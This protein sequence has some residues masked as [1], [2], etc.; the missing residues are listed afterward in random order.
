MFFSI[1]FLLALHYGCFLDNCFLDGYFLDGCF[2]NGC[3]LD[4]YFLNEWLL[5]WW[6]LFRSLLLGRLLLT[7]NLNKTPFGN[8]WRL[9]NPYFILNGC[10][11]TLFFYSPPFSQHSQLGHLWLPNSHCAAP[12][13]LTERYT[14]PLVTRCFPPN[15]YQ[16]SRGFP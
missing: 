15:P 13:W 11:D 5:L 16:G 6:L 8:I 9:G 1:C 4:G 12:V 10:L 3:F 7:F 2:Y 14:T